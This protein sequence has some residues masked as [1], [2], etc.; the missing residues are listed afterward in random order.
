VCVCVCICVWG[1]RAN[2]RHTRHHG[3][4]RVCEW[5]LHV[6]ECDCFHYFVN[7]SIVPVCL[8]NTCPE[9]NR[10]RHFNSGTVSQYSATR[11]T[12]PYRSDESPAK[13]PGSRA[14]KLLFCKWSPLY[15]GE[16]ESKA[17]SCKVFWRQRTYVYVHRHTQV[18]MSVCMIVWGATANQSEATSCQIYSEEQTNKH[19]CLCLCVCIGVWRARANQ[20]HTRHHGSTRVCE[21]SLHATVCVCACMLL[22]FR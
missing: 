21:W 17:T 7:L 20:H 6:R 8:S 15:R 1:A 14:D 4:S 11:N 9:I 18:C 16:T 2:Q 22:L 5:S 3:S 19:A 13:T 10:N 12:H